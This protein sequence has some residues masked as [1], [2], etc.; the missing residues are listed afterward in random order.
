MKDKILYLLTMLCVVAAFTLYNYMLDIK[1]VYSYISM[2]LGLFLGA[3][4]YIN[5]SKGKLGVDFLKSSTRELKFITWSKKEEV[6]PL[7]L[8]V[9][10]III[11]STI[12][13]WFFDI[14]IFKFISNTLH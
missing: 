9:V 3:V 5:T 13:I 8:K 7:T 11:V 1:E 4:F 2:I 6:I 10:G 14:A 12:I